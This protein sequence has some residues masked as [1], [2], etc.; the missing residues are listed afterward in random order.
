MTLSSVIA[1]SAVIPGLAGFATARSEALER[2]NAELTRLQTEVYSG[3]AS[4]RPVSASCLIAR[5]LK[6]RATSVQVKYR[7]MPLS[8]QVADERE[9]L[10]RHEVN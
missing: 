5:P 3:S 10:R 7:L 1:L 4:I 9:E 6:K 8:D 2:A